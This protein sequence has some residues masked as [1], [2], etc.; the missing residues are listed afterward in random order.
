MKTFDYTGL[1]DKY[2]MSENDVKVQRLN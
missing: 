1:N 2:T